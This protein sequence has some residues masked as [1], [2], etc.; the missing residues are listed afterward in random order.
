MC[1]ANNYCLIFFLL[2]ILNMAE[3]VIW[4][5]VVSWNEALLL[6]G[7]LSF[8]WLGKVGIKESDF[9]KEKSSGNWLFKLETETMKLIEEKNNAA[10]F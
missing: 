3:N 10:R 5:V 1:D 4:R 9:K 6:V 7:I 2:M 8:L